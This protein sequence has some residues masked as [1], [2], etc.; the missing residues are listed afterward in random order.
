MLKAFGDRG[1]FQAIFPKVN[2]STVQ[3]TETANYQEH[4]VTSDIFGQG[5]P[6]NPH[7]YLET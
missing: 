3:N 1:D 4:L 2:P 6:T 7:N 5:V